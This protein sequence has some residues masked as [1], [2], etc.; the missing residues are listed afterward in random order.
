ML[1]IRIA[2]VG[3]IFSAFSLISGL[4]VSGAEAQTAPP[5]AAGKPIQLL[6]LLQPNL[7]QPS[8]AKAKPR[9]K[10]AARPAGKTRTASRSR[11]RSQGI[12]GVVAQRRRS[13]ARTQ[14]AQAPAPDST[15]PPAPSAPPTELV[16][17]AL[18]PMPQP[19]VASAEATPSALVVG[20]RTVQ[21][22]LPNDANEIDLAAN[23]PPTQAS[24]AT[25]DGAAAS[26]PAIRDLTEAQPKS[27]SVRVATAQQPASEVGSTAWILQVM[28]AL[29]GAVAAGSVAWFLIGAAPQRTYG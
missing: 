26:T 17:A 24:A 21:L 1:N 10:L 19:G 28:A 4:A 23:D 20:G 22:A 25:P 12:H 13:H 15:W 14:I 3:A 11:M 5:E 27:D 29:G 18:T 2:T 6:Q 8:K 9:A 7:L 16:A